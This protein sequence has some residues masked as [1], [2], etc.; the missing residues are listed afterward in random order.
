MIVAT[1]SGISSIKALFIAGATICDRE[2]IEDAVENNKKIILR[3]DNILEDSKNRNTGMPRLI[4]FAKYADVIVYQSEWAK[5]LLKPICGDGIVIYN[6]VDTNIFYPRKENK[7][8][9]N[10]RIFYSRWGRGEGKN[11]N[12]VQYFWREYNLEKRDDTLVIVGKFGDESLKI[13]HPF[14]FHNDEDYE[15]HGVIQDQN[16]LAD[17]LR[18]CDVA[19][20]PYAFDAMSNSQLEA[21][22]CGLPII[23]MGNGGAKETVDFGVELNFD[24]SAIEIVNESIKL[25]EIFN[26]DDFKEKRGLNEMGSKYHALFELLKQDE[27]DV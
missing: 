7:D 8:W 12:V 25:K 2:T 21:Q 9:D 3:V 15:Y 22:S 4:E 10:I 16:K 19:L 6:G 5:R 18:S 1:L 17:I 20:L 14:E 23:Y 11:F 13:N 26:F 27:Y 24:K